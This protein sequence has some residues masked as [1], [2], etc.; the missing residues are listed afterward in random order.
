MKLHRPLYCGVLLAA[1]C[2]PRPTPGPAPADWAFESKVARDALADFEQ[3]M[4]KLQREIDDAHD[5]LLAGLRKARKRIKLPADPN[6]AKVKDLREAERLEAAIAHLEAGDPAP[7]KRVPRDVYSHR[8]NQYKLYPDPMTWDQARAFCE[9]VGGRLACI[10]TKDEFKALREYL[11]AE[12][13]ADADRNVPETFPWIGASDAESEGVWTWINGAS[14]D[15]KLFSP[16]KP[17]GGEQQNHAFLDTRGIDDHTGTALLPLL[18]EW[19]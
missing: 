12:L 2:G 5:D 11:D 10:E 17:E 18:C 19:D 9:S 7:F 14:V 4:Q 16:G 1:L 3:T 6:E 15:G 8:G 13:P